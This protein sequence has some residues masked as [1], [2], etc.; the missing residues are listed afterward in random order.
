MKRGWAKNDTDQYCIVADYSNKASRAIFKG[1]YSIVDADNPESPTL[2]LSTVYLTN[3]LGS[4]LIF[5]DA[6]LIGT[7]TGNCFYATSSKSA[8]IYSAC[9]SNVSVNGNVT[10]LVGTV[11]NGRYLIDSNVI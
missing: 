1:K 7:N 2:N 11:A 5:D 8:Y 9:Q 6:T 10:L 4:V 3:N